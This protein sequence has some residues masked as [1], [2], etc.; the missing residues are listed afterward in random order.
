[1]M[2]ILRYLKTRNFA[3]ITSSK[4]MKGDNLHAFLSEKSQIQHYKCFLEGDHVSERRKRRDVTYAGNLEIRK[5]SK[6]SV[7]TNFFQPN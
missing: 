1:M 6:V 3:A 2:Y 7:N 4:H 5:W